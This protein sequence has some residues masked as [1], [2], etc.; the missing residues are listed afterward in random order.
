MTSKTYA[1][2]PQQYA[3]LETSKVVLI[4]VPYDGTS[5]W[6]KGA[7]KGPEAFLNASENMELYDIET[8]TEV[9]K[10]GIYLA[11]AITEKSSPEAVVD[12]VHKTVKDYILR[13]KFV[14]I[15]GGEHSISIGTI[16]AFNETFDDLTVLQLDAHADL[17][18][19]YE[20]SKCNHACALYEASQ[21]TN[22]LQVGIRSMDVAETRVMDTE[23]TW[24]AHDMANDEYWM[25][26][27]IEAMGDNVFI[28]ID[29]DAFDPSILPS[30][31]TPEPGGLFWYETLEFLKQ[32]F[33]EKN[34][35]GFDIVE[36]CPRPEEKSSDFLAAKLYYKMLSYK[37]SE[38]DS[39]DEYES[40]FNDNKKGTS[41]S[42]FN[43]DNDDY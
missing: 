3:A 5:T 22:L 42:K 7:D 20:G 24:F 32:V 40:N 30:T 33:A 15:F 39:E 29:L 34:V 19:E 16:R 36:L 35:V 13:N 9:Y 6:Q 1:G 28:T 31:G 23:K 27:V 4:P 37:F 8:E 26:N 18:K 17:R 21:T 25:D 41:P 11:D 43:D 38:E 12:I 2:I 14:T 10:Q